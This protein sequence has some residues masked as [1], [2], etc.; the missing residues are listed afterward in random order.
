[1]TARMNH[2]MIRIGQTIARAMM[3][4]LLSLFGE[5]G[6]SGVMVTVAVIM[7]GG[8]MVVLFVPN[9]S[10]LLQITAIAGAWTRVYVVLIRPLLPLYTLET[11][12]LGERIQLRIN[13]KVGWAVR[14][15]PLREAM[16]SART[17]IGL[18]HIHRA[19]IESSFLR[20]EPPPWERLGLGIRRGA[21]TGRVVDGPCCIG[22]TECWRITV[23]TRF[24][25]QC[26]PG[27]NPAGGRILLCE[28]CCWC[29]V[30]G[31]QWSDVR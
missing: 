14:V 20:G 23:P 31:G 6:L 5:G 18:G 11:S 28:A 10:P 13:S 8:G 3:V 17:Q 22:G 21:H 26:K 19:A 25:T 30:R 16:W 7:L 24:H 1:M 29:S 9:A 4:E 12:T 2:A 27:A 15:K